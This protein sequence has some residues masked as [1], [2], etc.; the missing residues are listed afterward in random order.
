[1][2]RKKFYI[3]IT[4]MIFTALFV[5]YVILFEFPIR[6][7]A[8]LS[9][10]ENSKVRLYEDFTKDGYDDVTIL[11]DDYTWG[12]KSIQIFIEPQHAIVDQINFNYQIR[13]NDIYFEDWD[14]NGYKD[15]VAISNSENG[16][17]LTV[18]SVHKKKLLVK[19]KLIYDITKRTTTAPWN[20]V[21]ISLKLFT[22]ANDHKKKAI[23]L[24]NGGFNYECRSIVLIDRE[25]F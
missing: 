19:E 23:F 11:Y 21:P 22:D 12:K 1:M 18:Y 4:A 17:H 8:E 2:N 24:I 3:V 5:V 13:Y 7:N 16:T 9:E 15:I 25:T 14:N 20:P 6:I 10:R